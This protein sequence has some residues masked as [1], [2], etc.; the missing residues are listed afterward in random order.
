MTVVFM[1]MFDE[2]VTHSWSQDG[3]SSEVSDAELEEL[4]L[5]TTSSNSAYKTASKHVK[6]H[7]TPKTAKPGKASGKA[8]ATANSAKR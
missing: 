6:F 2:M 7:A 4:L 1:Y 5:K 8:K 3:L